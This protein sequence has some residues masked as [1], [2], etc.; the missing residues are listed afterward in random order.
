MIVGAET[1]IHASRAS[2]WKAVTDIERAADFMSGVEAVEIVQKPTDGIV[3]LRW[4]ET[5]ILFGK[6]ATVEK[7]ITEA[8]ANTS[9]VTRAESDGF[10]FITTTSISENGDGVVLRSTHDSQPQTV[11]A[12]LQS[13]PMVFF[14]GIIRKAILQDLNDI[15]VAAERS[16]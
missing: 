5:R 10:I 13:I 15:K 2:V 14:R 12:R 6:P 3:G 9:Y 16:K 4:R 7:W 8:T 1:V 11:V